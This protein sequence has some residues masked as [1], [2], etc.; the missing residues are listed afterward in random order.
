MALRRKN[1]NPKRHPTERTRVRIPDPPE[2]N[3]DSPMTI[4]MRRPLNYAAAVRRRIVLDVPDDT[5]ER[6]DPQTPVYKQPV[7]K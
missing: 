5:D 7:N 3:L 2:E 4:A 1:P 6:P